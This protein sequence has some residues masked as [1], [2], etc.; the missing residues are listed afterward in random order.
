[1]KDQRTFSS[2]SLN[3]YMGEEIW[4]SRVVFYLSQVD[5]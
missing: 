4:I 2:F 1:M 5:I 3:F